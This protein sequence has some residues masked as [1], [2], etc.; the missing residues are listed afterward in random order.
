MRADLVILSDDPL[1]TAPEDL[2]AIT[3]RETIKDG[4][5]VYRA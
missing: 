5:V 1:A 2:R 3:V 4:A